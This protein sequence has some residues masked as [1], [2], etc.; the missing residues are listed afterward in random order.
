MGKGRRIIPILGGDL[1]L[2]NSYT[3]PENLVF[4][5]IAI[6]GGGAA[7][8]F[9]AANLPDLPGCRVTLYEKAHRLM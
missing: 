6:I 2:R 3:G 7:G 5:E 4:M 8:C 1:R 9:A